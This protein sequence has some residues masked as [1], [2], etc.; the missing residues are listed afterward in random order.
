[1]PDPTSCDV[2]KETAIAARDVGF[3]ILV[4]A[5]VLWRLERNLNKIALLLQGRR[6]D[7]RPLN[8]LDPEK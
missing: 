4:A 3:P 1:M 2:V 8:L 5:F 7:D 6:K